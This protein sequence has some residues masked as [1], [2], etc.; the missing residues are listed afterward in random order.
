MLPFNTTM[1]CVHMA[2]KLSHALHETGGRALPQNVLFG[3]RFILATIRELSLGKA[4][5]VFHVGHEKLVCIV[6]HSCLNSGRVA[7]ES[8]S[9]YATI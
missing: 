8:I 7:F 6:V 9:K 2:F 5:S 3:V 4:R 1:K